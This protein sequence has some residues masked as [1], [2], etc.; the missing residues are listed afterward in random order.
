MPHKSFQLDNYIQIDFILNHGRVRKS[1]H[2]R[3]YGLKTCKPRFSIDQ[4]SIKEQSNTVFPAYLE[5]HLPHKTHS[6]EHE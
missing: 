3:F 5:L 2:N 6:L 1:S 4:A